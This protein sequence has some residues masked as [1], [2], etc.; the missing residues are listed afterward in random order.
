MDFNFEN[1]DQQ[2]INLLKAILR[3]KFEE[4]IRNPLIVQLLRDRPDLVAKYEPLFADVLEEK[5]IENLAA[6]LRALP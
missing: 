4:I 2:S 5:M 6:Y 3:E 1:L